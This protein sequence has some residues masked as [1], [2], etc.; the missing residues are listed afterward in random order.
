[1]TFLITGLLKQLSPSLIPESLFSGL[2][3]KETEKKFKGE[4][5][6]T[7]K[8]SLTKLLIDSLKPFRKKRREFLKR[9]V[10]VKEIL[11]KGKNKA[12]AIASLTIQRVK[13]RTGL[14]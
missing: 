4:G 12:Q 9:E 7:F 10:F 14:L 1:M 8:K 11:E 5:Y 3:I 2:S 13:K 6:E